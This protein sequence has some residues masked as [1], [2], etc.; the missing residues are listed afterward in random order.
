MKPLPF[1][2]TPTSVER[3]LIVLAA[4]RLEGRDDERDIAHHGCG[5]VCSETVT[6]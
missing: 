2:S 6:R 4:E 1:G 3:V 5:L